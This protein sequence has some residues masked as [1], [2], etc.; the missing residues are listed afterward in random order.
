MP[1]HDRDATLPQDCIKIWRNLVEYAVKYQEPFTSLEALLVR[2]DETAAYQLKNFEE[3]CILRL[4]ATEVESERQVWSRAYIKALKVAS[5]LAVADDYLCPTISED[6]AQWA[7]NLISRDVEVFKSRL[8]SG[9]V[10]LGDDTRQRKI[11]SIISKYIEARSIPA[12]YNVPI[13]MHK[14]GLIPRKYIQ[15]RTGSL[16]AFTD[17]KAG[18]IAA[19]DQALRSFCANGWLIEV[20]HD[21]V[22]E[23]YGFHGKTFRVID[24][25]D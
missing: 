14:D 19:L 1:N 10:G 5:L 4:N 22:V 18:H 11:A 15:M 16:A 3:M 24:L 21:K 12:S 25:P 23:M 6:H 20:K 9:D 7:I 17:H 13:Q 2:P 8:Q